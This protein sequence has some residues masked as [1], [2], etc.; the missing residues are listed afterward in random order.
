MGSKSRG[1]WNINACL[2]NCKNRDKKCDTCIRFSEYEEDS[3]QST[4]T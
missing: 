1:N 2:R 3:N 4:E